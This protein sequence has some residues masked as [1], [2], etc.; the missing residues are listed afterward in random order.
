[1]KKIAQFIIFLILIISAISFYNIYFKK[2]ETI[3]Y[4]DLVKKETLKP[5]VSKK[6]SQ[7]NL[8]K[9]LMYDVKF[10]DNS[11]YSISS[12]LSEITYS[13]NDE[14][15][16]MQGVIAKIIDE[17]NLSF[18]IVSNYAVFN[19]NTYETLFTK[20]VKITY[21]DNEISSQKLL[22]N[23]DENIVTISEN[24]LYEGLQGLIQTD[25]IRINL[26]SKNVEIFMNNSKN[27][28]KI[29]SK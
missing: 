10:E 14:I 4:S 1:M 9:N 23:F 16:N 12:D 28:I 8:I 22:L 19:N 27:K 20:N 5:Q 17:N 6:E 7:S 13:A 2:D 29:T 21:L 24:V 25:N 3:V 18:T 15:V 11:Q 26:K